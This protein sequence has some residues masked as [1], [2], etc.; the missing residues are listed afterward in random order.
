MYPENPE[1]TQVIIGSMNMG[2]VSDTARTRT[3][4]LF[5]PRILDLNGSIWCNFNLNLIYF[6]NI[7]LSM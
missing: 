1:E 5:R 2:Y 3:R 4:N 7:Q 6:I